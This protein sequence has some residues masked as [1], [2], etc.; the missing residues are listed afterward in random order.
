MPDPK[1][2]PAGGPIDRQ[3]RDLDATEGDSLVDGRLDPDAQSP[4]DEDSK[5]FDPK[6]ND[7]S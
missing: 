4:A 6:E 3:N 5:P 7:P 2:M 1:P